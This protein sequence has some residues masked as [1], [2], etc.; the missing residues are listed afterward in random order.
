LRLFFRMAYIKPLLLLCILFNYCAEPSL[1]VYGIKD[2]P[3]SLDPSF[4]LDF[5][6]SQ[7]SAQI[8]EN[9]VI[10]DNDCKTLNPCLAQSW[11]ISEDK[12]TYTFVLRDSIFFHDGTK[13]SS[14]SVL[15][16]FDWLRVKP[17]RSEIYD[18]VKR[19]DVIDSLTFKIILHKPY[20]IF[21]YVLASPESFQIMS[22]RAISLYD[23]LIGRHPV[24]TG[25][26]Q[27][28]KWT[29]G[30]KIVLNRNKK[31]WGHSGQINKVV[32][33]YYDGKFQGEEFLEKNIIDIL[34]SPTAYSLDRLKW[35]GFIDYHTFVPVSILFL[36]F[37][38]EAYPFNN[39]L[40]RKAILKAINVPKFVHNS[41]RGNAMVAKGPLPPNFFNY[42][43]LEQDHFN[44]EEAK[45]ILTQQGIDSMVIN[46]D[47]PRIA[48]TRMIKIEFIKHELKKIGI[49]LNVR[50]HHSWEEL[51]RAILDDSAQLFYNGGRSDI[52]GDSYNILYGFFHSKSILNSLKYH[53]PLVDKWL[54][55]A[56]QESD[57]EKRKKLYEKIVAKILDDTP[58]IFL[59]HNIP[60]FAY[61]KQRIKNIITN[62]Y[63]II[64]FNHIQLY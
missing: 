28:S 41:N 55:M 8:Y 3:L 40:I 25:P 39:K 50:A 60:N 61:N 37:N 11:N 56:I 63:G 20:S 17:N 51:D 42:D 33:K 38:N 24:G 22:E 31:Y 21:L 19:L 64:K 27:L 14:M 49:H 5:D 48:L 36:G 13:L 23:S 30:D 4:G 7:I 29:E 58:A 52:I 45:S 35:T 57:P 9:L 46:F 59:Y 2:N 43:H 47:F 10:L 6:E 62:P 32:F 18:K 16:T 53:E 12:C 1:V 54:N 26:F 34:Y 44:L 15:S